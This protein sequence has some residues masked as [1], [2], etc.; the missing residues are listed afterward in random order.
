MWSTFTEMG[1]RFTSVSSI[2]SVPPT[3]TTALGGSKCRFFN[4]AKECMESITFC[5]GNKNINRIYGTLCWQDQF[6]WK[7][8]FYLSSYN[9]LQVKKN[10]WFNHFN[11]FKSIN[12]VYITS[13]ILIPKKINPSLA[14]WNKTLSPPKIFLT[15]HFADSNT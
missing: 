4:C 14:V 9:N 15:L 8:H 6:Y 13:V 5:P 10:S 2:E 7:Q 1:I 3:W 11:I 12:T